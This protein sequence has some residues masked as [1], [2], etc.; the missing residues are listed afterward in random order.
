[1]R[2]DDQIFDLV[3]EIAK[4]L[5]E[6]MSYDIQAAHLTLLQVQALFF[7]K[8]KK[9]AQMK[10]I[11]DQFKV[12]MSTATSLLD[13]LVTMGLVVRIND[14]K[15]RRIVRIRL[16]KKGNDFVDSAMRQKRK[17]IKSLLSY[18]KSEDKKNLLRILKV[19]K[20]KIS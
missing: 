18:L 16:T 6:Q 20:N 5:K 15:D 17:K 10:E 19:I 12:K 3:F 13:K 14:F 9:N 2:Y 4:S 7:I 8:M 11:A 1:M